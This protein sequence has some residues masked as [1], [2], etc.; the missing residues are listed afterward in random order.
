MKRLLFLLLVL[1]SVCR[2]Q[3]ALIDEGTIPSAYI[4]PEILDVTSYPIDETTEDI[5]YVIILNGN[6]LVE[7]EVDY[8]LDTGYGY[9]ITNYLCWEG[10][11]DILLENLEGELE[12]HY[13]IYIKTN[14]GNYIY[15][16]DNNFTLIMGRQ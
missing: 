13:R 5:S 6:T 3:N 2:G 12:Y 1:T 14:T 11:N 15:S 4:P 9:E 8:G 10:C 16:A 7:C